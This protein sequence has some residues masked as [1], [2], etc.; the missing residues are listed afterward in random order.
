MGRTL[1]ILLA[2]A[3]MLTAWMPGVRAG[4]SSFD[5]RLSAS[6]CAD[7]PAEVASNDRACP[8]CASNGSDLH[9]TSNASPE[10]CGCACPGCTCAGHRHSDDRPLPVQTSPRLDL[11]VLLP[12]SDAMTGWV[13]EVAP[14]R[15][16]TVPPC[17]L[18]PGATPA[19]RA[20]LGAWLT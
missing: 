19:P 4:S 3:F 17:G 15:E 11:R 9:P 1:G 5:A 16:R 8:L 7:A 13:M 20:Q 14:P 6:C 2:L 10:S 18:R 12:R